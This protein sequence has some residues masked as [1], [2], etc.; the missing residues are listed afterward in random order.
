[1]PR[2]DKS[3][4][5]SANE[6]GGDQLHSETQTKAAAYE[7]QLWAAVSR[8][9]QPHFLFVP[10]PQRFASFNMFPAEA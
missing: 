8:D 3:V 9:Y 10:Q 6:C 7:L 4:E 1:L 2:A 5:P